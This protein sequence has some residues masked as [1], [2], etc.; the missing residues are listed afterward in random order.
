M[1]VTRQWGWQRWG[2]RRRWLG[3][4]VRR[5]RGSHRPA[6][7][8]LGERRRQGSTQGPG[9]N[10]SPLSAPRSPSPILA[11][12]PGVRVQTRV[13]PGLD[14]GVRGHLRVRPGL[15][16]RVRVHLGVR[17]GLDPRVRVHG[18]VRP[19]LDPGARGHGRARFASHLLGLGVDLLGRALSSDWSVAG[20]TAGVTAGAATGAAAGAAAGVTVGTAVGIAAGG[21]TGGV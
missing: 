10:Q 3:C 8:R 1:E 16:P 12:D 11:L 2:A 7:E 5:R 21:R 14:P 13:R 19:G 18:R 9:P 15:D 6:V 17:P 20:I 4:W